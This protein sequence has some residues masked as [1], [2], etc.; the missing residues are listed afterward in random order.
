[1]TSACTSRR[2]SLFHARK[3]NCWWSA[4]CAGPGSRAD[5]WVID[6]GTGSGCIAITLANHLPQATV[7]AIDVSPAALAV[8][9]GN[10]ARVGIGAAI[11]WLE[12]DLLAP[13]LP[14]TAGHRPVLLTANLPYVTDVE[15]TELADGVKSYEPALAL[16]GG[17]DGLDLV[18]RLLQQVAQSMAHGAAAGD[19]AIFMEIGWRQGPLALALTERLLPGWDAALHQDY[20]GQDRIISALRRAP[21]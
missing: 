12:G 17:E 4:R 15:W 10:E 6:V 7:T 19:W 8:A 16:R 18:R 11:Q 20:A 5:L 13:L 21:G 1:M 2:T 9:R 3:R 14:L